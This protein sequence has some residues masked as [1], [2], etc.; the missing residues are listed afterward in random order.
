MWEKIDAN[1]GTPAL[2]ILS[3]GTEYKLIYEVPASGRVCLREWSKDEAKIT[4][5]VK[6]L[7]GL[8]FWEGA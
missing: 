3:D 5:Q 7:G 8:A 1:L 4:L 2:F 6:N